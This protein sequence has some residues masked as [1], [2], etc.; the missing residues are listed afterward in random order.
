MYLSALIAQPALASEQN[1][2]AVCSNPTRANF[3]FVVLKIIQW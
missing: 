3:L 1:S 2:V